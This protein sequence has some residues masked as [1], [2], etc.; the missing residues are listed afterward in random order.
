MYE[1]TTLINNNLITTVG[2]KR[3]KNSCIY[4][5]HTELP[6]LSIDLITTDS[7]SMLCKEYIKQVK[8]SLCNKVQPHLNYHLNINTPSTQYQ[9]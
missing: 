6:P 5:M 3:R 4:G 7:E 8:S 9:C 2:S 1:N